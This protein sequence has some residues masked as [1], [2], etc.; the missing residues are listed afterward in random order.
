MSERAAL[1]EVMRAMRAAGLNVGCAGNAAVRTP[2]GCLVTPSGI[3]PDALA[4]TDVVE[5]APDGAVLNG[6]RAPSS[7][8]PLH[9]GLLGARPEFGALVHAHSPYATALSCLR[10][11]VPAFHYM[12]A[13]A[14][15]DDIRCT[16]YARFGSAEL[17]RHAITAMQG[18]SACLLA[19]HGVIAAGDTLQQALTLLETVEDLCRQYW[20][21][22]QIDPGPTLLTGAQM[23]AVHKRFK[24]Y[25]PGT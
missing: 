19:N 16:S 18:R 13:L 12:V 20:L 21:A 14:G 17:A 15:G 9:T 8:W 1:V 2:N 23:R 5:L 10:R 25:G 7:E 3:E 24:T 11:D 6:T 22:L 4:P